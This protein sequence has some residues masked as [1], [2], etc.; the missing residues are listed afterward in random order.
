MMIIVQFN[1]KGAPGLAG[2]DWALIPRSLRIKRR[3]VRRIQNW[4][5]YLLEGWFADY[6]AQFD[7]R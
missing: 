3:N 1:G 6:V 4:C 7:F 2:M 5:I